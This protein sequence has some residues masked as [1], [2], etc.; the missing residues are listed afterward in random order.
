MFVIMLE[1][2]GYA[3][4]SATPP[5]TPTWRAR[6]P[7]RARCSRTTTRPATRATTTTSRSSPASRRTS[8]NQAD[9]QLFD[10]FVGAIMLPDGVE[11]GTGCVYPVLGGQHRHAAVRRRAQLE[12]LRGGHGQRPQSRDGRVRAPGAR[13]GRR[14]PESRGRRRLRH[15]PRPVR[16]LPLG[17]RQPDLLRHSTSSRSARRAG[18]CR[19]PRCAARPGWRPTCSRP[20]RRPPSRS[21]PP[22]SATTATTTRAPT[23]RAAPR[24]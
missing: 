11:A 8:Q 2:E 16:L 18:R 20:R 13:R 10:D 14:N 19:R 12:G 22:T 23:S 4:R 24:R 17:D 15:P 21:S 7:R 5:P 9:C 1:N 3:A 6:C